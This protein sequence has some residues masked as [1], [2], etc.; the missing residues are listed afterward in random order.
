MAS[1]GNPMNIRML[2]LG[3][4]CLQDGTG[5]DIKKLFESAFSHFHSASYGSIY[6][7]LAQLEREGLVRHRSEPGARH[8]E[9]K[10]YT[11][12]EEGRRAFVQALA[13]T[14]AME[15]LRSDYLVTMFFAHLLPTDVLSAKLDEIEAQYRGELDYL[16]SVKAI[17]GQSAGIRF[18]VE[19]GIVVYRAK[20]DHLRARR[21]T[22]LA[23]HRSAPTA[24]AEHLP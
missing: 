9:R 22:L 16:E 17:P 14:P 10:V 19:Q 8:P 15:Q 7:A 2:C 6:P 3:A 20:L 21:P 11:A 23:E 4:L 24:T 5:Y 1:P 12:T 18:T 13:H